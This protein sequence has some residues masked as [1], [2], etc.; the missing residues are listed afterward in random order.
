MSAVVDFLS[1][2]FLLRSRPNGG[3]AVL[4]RSLWVTT[5]ICAMVLP[6]KSYC[7]ADTELAFSAAQLKVEL[8]QMI[9]WFG[10]VFAGT[11]AAFYSRFAAQWSYL[12]SLYNQITA[13]IASAPAGH[14][15]NEALIGWKA[16]F[17]E[18]AQDLHLARKS[19][20]ASVIKG[21]LQDPQVVRVFLSYTDGGPDRLHDLQ[22]QL[23]CVAV[24][25]A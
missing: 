14:F 22:L 5:L 12:A 1:G 20:F 13:T 23:N 24:T 9:P 4:F 18:D 8:G 3:T 15:P 10:A 6:I 2:E 11:Y 21:F 17:I 25:P 19:M 16:A 7:A